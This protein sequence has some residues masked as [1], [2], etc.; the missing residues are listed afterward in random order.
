MTAVN[1][2]AH[3]PGWRCAGCA[4]QDASAVV[5]LAAPSSTAPHTQR[6]PPHLRQHPNCLPTPLGCPRGA[7]PPVPSPR[8]PAGLPRG[9]CSAGSHPQPTGGCTRNIS[10]LQLSDMHLPLGQERSG[11]EIPTLYMQ[12]CSALLEVPHSLHCLG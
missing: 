9:S 5:L 11:R 3:Q 1:S 4:C 2:S 6:S 8:Q 10:T 12:R 7:M